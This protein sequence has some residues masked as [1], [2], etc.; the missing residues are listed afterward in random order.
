VETTPSRPRSRA[1]NY[2][3]ATYPPFSCWNGTGAE[4]Y[5]RGLRDTGPAAGRNSIGLYVHLP[6]CAKRCD[7]CYYL[8]YTG[9]TQAIGRYVEALVREARLYREQ[10]AWG[11]RRI[12]F[13]YF[14]G[15]TPTLLSAAEIERMLDGI[16]EQLPWADDAEVTFEC[17]PRSTSRS[18]LEALARGGVTRLSLGVQQLDDAVLAGSGRIHRIADVLRAYSAIRDVGFDQV[19]LDL[20]A[21]LL[22]QSEGSFAAGLARVV[23]LAPESVTIYQLEVPLNTPLYRSPNASELTSWSE[24][25]ARVRSGFELLER[26]GYTVRSAYSAVRDPLRHRFLYQDAQYRG[27][28]LLGLGA[29]SFGHIDGVNQQNQASLGR[30]LEAIDAGRLPL[31]RGYAMSGEERLVREL[32]LQLKLG[33]VELTPLRRRWSIDPQRRFSASLAAL[34]SQGLLNVEDDAIVLTREGLLQADDLLESFYLPRHR[35]LRY[36]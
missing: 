17:A 28:W 8:S 33:R 27:A 26:E 35:G 31:W 13:V 23:G 15:G 34:S 20:I 2:F 24:T 10:G 18:K 19:N 36:S 30:Y 11:A 3:V 1:G 9:R 5:L 29:S 21:G 22:G 16:R 7:Y 25:R 32:V 14:G 4:T 6:F 12:E